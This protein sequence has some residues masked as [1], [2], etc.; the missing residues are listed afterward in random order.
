LFLAL[1]GGP[2]PLGAASVPLVNSAEVWSYHKGTN[3][4]Q[5]DWKTASDTELET[6]QWA[7]G[8]G[9]F[10]FADN[11]AETG[12]CHTLLNDMLGRYTTVYM[13]KSFEVTS[14][15]APELHLLLTMDW[16]DGFVAWLD[17]NLLTNLYVTLPAGGEPG[18]AAAASGNH[19]SSLGNS[20]PQAPTTFDCGLVG[21]R[22]S[23]GTHTLAILGLNSS[24]GSSDFV[25][26]ADLFLDSL[27]E[28]PSNSISGTLTADTTF[29]A[30]NSPY[31][32]AG[33]VTVP[34]NVTLTIEPGTT[35]YLAPG[36]DL[37][38][39]SGGR[40]LAEG[41]AEAPIRLTRPS[42]TADLWGH[43]T[44]NG[45][46]GSPE[47]RIAHAY[48]E[49]NG[50][51]PCIEVAAG[52]V[53]LDHVSFGTTARQYLAL[54]GA[55]FLVSDCHFPAATAA[56]EAV[57]GTRGI[58]SG[59][60]G[61]IRNCFFGAVRG[62]SDTIDFT[63]GNR[64]G[65]I[66]QFVD[67]VFMGSG[68]DNLDLDSTDAWV[69]GNIFLHM[70]KNGSP[71]TSSGV[72]G[73]ND[74]G[75]AGDVT[76]IGNIFYDCDQ[77][78]MCKQGNFYA[79]INNTIVRQTH[80]GGLDTEGAVLC[81]QDN[82]MTEGRGMYLEGNVMVDIEKLTRNVTS[83]V[84]TFANNLMPLPWP[85]PGQGNSA[86]DPMLTYLPQLSETYFT[87]WADA[88]VMKQ[89]FIPKPGSPAI[90]SGPNGADKGGCIPGG[91]SI[92]GEP[93]TVT[94]QTSATLSVG[95]NRTGNGIPV[96][97]WPNGAGYTHYRWRLDT[98]A[99]SAETPI[100]SPINLSNL[101]A[102]PHYIEVA[103]KNDAGFYQDDPGFGSRAAP[104]VSKTWTVRTVHPPY[105]IT[106]V[107]LES[108]RI[109]LQFPVLAGCTYTVE[110]N[111][112][113]DGTSS[114]TALTN[115]PAQSVAGVMVVS[116]SH[117]AAGTRFYRVIT[118]ARP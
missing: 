92:S 111:S 16:D 73:G 101:P 54:D 71:D 108:D 103:G 39:N 48:I 88:Q 68:D 109:L 105:Q 1:T 114:W 110:L 17:G 79:L 21:S 41:T 3:A 81:L 2:S 65:P 22:L 25:Q 52:T 29:Y 56:F 91:V 83:G 64:P 106:S 59:G 24:S 94:A 77:A 76:I 11:S 50:S 66:I 118:P 87:N 12:N 104:T 93:D 46:V 74:D 61:I 75:N 72:S 78:V 20:S 86:A 31:A 55:S 60:R 15:A 70:H 102:G 95:V 115:I 44:I 112:S 5:A 97:D 45:Q 14:P 34:A 30:S 99:W 80:Q 9:G 10:G 4:P 27:P 51:S 26:V 69:Q 47:S 116:D 33:T 32:M 57:H 62:Y 82:N 28:P 23:A 117:P 100:S 96:S 67:N 36:T 42:S 19:E 49:G 18:H 63:G 58:K 107:E 89:W 13:R 38:V 8:Q 7:T 113:L 40:L 85:G 6:N 90:G 37:T 53:Y 84:V 98:N 43:L 35:V